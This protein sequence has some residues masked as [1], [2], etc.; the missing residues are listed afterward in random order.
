MPLPAD[1]A[2]ALLSAGDR[3]GPM[4]GRILWFPEATS[5]NDIAGSMAEHG[6]DEGSVV[7]ANF[8]STGRGRRGRSWSSP[9]GAGIYASI[10]L[11]PALRVIPL[12]TIAAGVA[13]AEGIAG[14]T[15]L[16][17]SLKWPNDL[18]VGN[19]KLAGI[20]AEGGTR[21]VVLGFGI[22]VL[23]AAYPPDVAARAT[24]IAGELGRAVDRGLVLAG[25]LVAVWR[26]YQDLSQFRERDVLDA[27]RARAAPML[28]KDIEWEHDGTVERGRAR[29]IDEAGAL[30]MDTG[31][32]IVRIVSGE[33]RWS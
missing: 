27:W 15:G 4:T 3:L 33:V 19:R 10:V 5:T 18:Y 16:E 8:Q 9:P 29:G 12:V 25:C 7:V 2:E 6:A 11:R 21:H 1:V 20:L 13:I 17:P 28:D 32:G 31:A 14:A 22:N 23:P 26:R 24:S 30:L